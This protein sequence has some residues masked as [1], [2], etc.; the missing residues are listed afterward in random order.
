MIKL[1]RSQLDVNAA[2]WH[3][4]HTGG[5]GSWQGGIHSIMTHIGSRL[6]VSGVKVVNVQKA[7]QVG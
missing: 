5:T 7:R 3:T 4:G 2:P 6:G 1:G